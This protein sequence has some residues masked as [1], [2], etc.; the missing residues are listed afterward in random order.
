M[1]NWNSIGPNGRTVRWDAM[2][3]RIGV[4]SHHLR[5]LLGAI[6]YIVLCVFVCEVEYFDV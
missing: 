6:K 1:T 3:G 5:T 2:T 4:V